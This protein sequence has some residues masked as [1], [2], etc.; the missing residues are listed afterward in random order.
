MVHVQIAP[1]LAGG[2]LAVDFVHASNFTRRSLSPWHL[3]ATIRSLRG[4]GDRMTYAPAV[5]AH[6]RSGYPTRQVGGQIH[7]PLQVLAVTTGEVVLGG[8]GWG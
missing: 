2:Q 5:A 4:A 3:V 1:L 6:D 8:M 7:K